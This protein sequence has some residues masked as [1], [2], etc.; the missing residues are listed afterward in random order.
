MSNEQNELLDDLISYYNTEDENMGDT[1]VIPSVES[2]ES[3]EEDI[4]GD[5]LVMNI[6]P[7][8]TEDE[9]SVTEETTVINVSPAT[10]PEIP[11]D[12]VLGSMYVD[13]QSSIPQ[14]TTSNSYAEIDI[15]KVKTTS[16]VTPTRKR[17]VWYS[18][19]PLWAT[20]IV[21]AMIV[22]SYFFYITDTG[23]IGLYKS[24]F[25]YNFHLIMRVFGV[26]YDPAQGVPVIGPV[27][28]SGNPFMITAHA[29]GSSYSGINKKLSTIPFAG[30]D[31]AKFAKYK[32]GVVCA[33]SN[34]IC[35]INKKGEKKWGL[36]TQ[37]S[38][39]LL[40]VAGKYIAVAG[41]DSTYLDLYKDKKLLYSIKV[42]EKIKSC[43][44][45]EKGD[46]AL[47]TDKTAY[48]GAV[49]VYNKKGEEVFSWISGVNYITSAAM[50]K[51][52]NVAVSLVSTE[53]SVKSYVMLFDI[54]ETDPLNGA[55]LSGSLVFDS[56]PYK[57]DAYVCA[58]N[59]ISSVN[60]DGELKYNIRFDNMDI[61][62]TASDPKG[63]RAVSYTE[64]Y[65]P[66]INIYNH[67]GDSQSVIATES[68]PDCIDLYKSVVLYN[69]GRDVICGDAKKTKTKYSAPMTVK[70]LVMMNKNT[71]MVAYENS[72]EIIKI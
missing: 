9:F 22:G 34:Y 52:R 60:S 16:D 15:P 66:Y 50:L 27:S 64:K 39:P 33:K 53:N 72:L 44:V 40:S 65:L 31:S 20:I 62:H 42:S 71:Y 12:E 24:N 69:N 48:K 23:I 4:L 61:T 67:K 8:T 47:V 63:W 28:D 26:D 70:A 19:K 18:L 45:S 17:G 57:K 2:N 56:T 51:S 21:T 11:Q 1:T 41:K 29:E 7:Q 32:N 14:Q 43:S 58:D 10:E 25:S 68:V 6:E 59:A 13:V 3:V 30:A 36:E 5:T 46:V 35:F 37:I 54:F 49:S 38:N 55:E